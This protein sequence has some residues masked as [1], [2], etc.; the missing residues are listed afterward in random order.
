[1]RRSR[2]LRAI[3]FDAGNTLVRMNYGVIAEQLRARGHRVSFAAGEEAEQRARV[4]LD[5]HLGAGA[6]PD[7][8]TME[9]ASTESR[10]THGR[11]LRYILERLGITGEPEIEEIARWRRGYNLPGGPWDVADPGGEAGPRRAQGGGG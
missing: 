6:R 11:Y 8:G 3:L 1:M 9:R 5:V 10:T 2:P 4:R 7:S